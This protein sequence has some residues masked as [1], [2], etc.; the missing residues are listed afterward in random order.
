MG[1]LALALLPLPPN[2]LQA[3]FTGP[4]NIAKSLLDNYLLNTPDRQ[5]KV[6]VCYINLLQSYVSP[7]FVGVVTMY[8]P[9]N[10]EQQSVV[11]FISSNSI[12][13][14]PPENTDEDGNLPTRGKVVVLTDLPFICLVW[15]RKRGMTPLS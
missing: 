8:D 12:S 7:V 5:R 14:S 3:K 4:Y 15:Q 1:D 6:H 11:S 2:L 13:D 9:S 10:P